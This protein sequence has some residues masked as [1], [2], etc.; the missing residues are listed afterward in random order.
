MKRRIIALLIVLLFILSGCGGGS[1]KKDEWYRVKQIYVV[2]GKVRYELSWDLDDD[3]RKSVEYRNGEWNGEWTYDKDGNILTYRYLDG[4]SKKNVTVE[5]TYEKGL[6]IKEVK[7]EDLTDG[8]VKETVT[9]Y[10]YEG[11]RLIKKTVNGKTAEEYSY[12][13]DGSYTVSKPYADIPEFYTEVYDSADRLLESD[14]YS[15][16]YELN[17]AGKVTNKKMYANG[18]LIEENDYSFNEDGKVERSTRTNSNGTYETVYEYE[19]GCVVYTRTMGIDGDAA[20]D[21]WQEV[22]E[23][24][25]SYVNGR[26]DTIGRNPQ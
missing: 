15:Y 14:P 2:D 26:G 21:M 7:R 8:I 22:K 11:E 5:Y 24:Y 23:Y 18:I 20:T 16:T 4:S 25:Y 19:N 13:E 17:D 12:R 3:G 9:E 6:L 1:S 10:E